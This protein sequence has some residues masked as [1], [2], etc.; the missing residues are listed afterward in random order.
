MMVIGVN[1]T[2]SNAVK[3]WTETFSECKLLTNSSVF[4]SVTAIDSNAFKDVLHIS[5]SGFAMGPMENFI[6][7]YKWY[8][9]KETCVLCKSLFKIKVIT[10]FS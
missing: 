8:N 6:N 4:V 1:N 5:Y 2:I 3:K 10:L 9:K 7:W